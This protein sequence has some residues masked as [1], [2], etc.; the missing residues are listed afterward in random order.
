MNTNQLLC[1]IR[2]NICLTF[3]ARDIYSVDTLPT[4]VLTFPTAYICNTDESYLPG[5]HW[6]VFWFHDPVHSEC[7]DSFGHL[8]GQ[9]NTN[10]EDFLTKNTNVC[11]YNNVPFQSKNSDV[12][13]Y[14]VLC[15]LLMKCNGTKLPDIVDLLEKS[16]FPDQ[17][18]VEYVTKAFDCI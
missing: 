17:Y 18:V 12:C 2:E 5:K 1:V 16:V 14:Y 7:F 9:Y 11:V 6:I 13:G 10:F 8:P 4:K 3:V 15:Y